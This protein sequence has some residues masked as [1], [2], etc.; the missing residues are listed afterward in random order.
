MQ[1]EMARWLLLLC[2]VS[3]RAAP[4]AQVQGQA[5]SVPLGM[6]YEGVRALCVCVYEC[7]THA[8]EDLCVSIV[9]V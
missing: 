4:R 9:G 5:L 3:V 8:C 2:S 6:L 1:Q 7:D